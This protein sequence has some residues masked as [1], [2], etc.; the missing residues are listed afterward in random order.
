MEMKTISVKMTDEEIAILDSKARKANMSRS[1]Y[2]R[3]NLNNRVVFVIDKSKELYQGLIK[4]DRAIEATEIKKG[5]GELTVIREAEA[6]LWQ[7][8]L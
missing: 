3:N 4:L 7:L 1:D 6:L 8:Y 5:C 2:I